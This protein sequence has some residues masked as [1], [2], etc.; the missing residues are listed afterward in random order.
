MAAEHDESVMRPQRVLEGRC[1]KH[2]IP[3]ERRADCGWCPD[4]GVGYSMTWNG[5]EGRGEL[6]LHFAPRI[7][8]SLSGRSES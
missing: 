4:C 5:T 1:P 3:L 2:D 6:S 8:P 7:P